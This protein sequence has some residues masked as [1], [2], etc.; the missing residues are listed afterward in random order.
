MQ[1]PANWAPHAGAPASNTLADFMPGERVVWP[2]PER[3]H[4]HL[5]MEEELS[6][7]ILER[8]EQIEKWVRL[9]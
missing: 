6:L 1:S 7:W 4:W 2:P 5:R 3:L 9:F 8:E